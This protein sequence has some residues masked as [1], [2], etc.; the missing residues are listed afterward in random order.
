MS[1]LFPDF[2]AAIFS[3]LPQHSEEYIATKQQLKE[4]HYAFND[5]YS[6]RDEELLDL[7][8]GPLQNMSK[9]HEFRMQNTKQSLSTVGACQQ[10]INKA[11]ISQHE[12]WVRDKHQKYLKETKTVKDGETVFERFLLDEI[13][14]TEKHRLLNHIESVEQNDGKGFVVEEGTDRR[15]EVAAS[16]EQDGSNSGAKPGQQQAASRVT[17]RLSKLEL[18]DLGLPNVKINSHDLEGFLKDG[19]KLKDL[20]NKQ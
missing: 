1:S 3:M 10:E 6:I 11:L 7:E 17:R 19:G 5:F 16:T 15:E 4:V 8:N 20:I 13:Y 14:R 9:A 12:P 18:D 2:Q